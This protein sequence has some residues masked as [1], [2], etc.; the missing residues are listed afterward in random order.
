MKPI[1]DLLQKKDEKKPDQKPD[2][3]PKAGNHQLDSRAKKNYRR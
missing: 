2:K 1:Y 3:K